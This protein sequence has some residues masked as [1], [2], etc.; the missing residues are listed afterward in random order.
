MSNRYADVWADAADAASVHRERNAVS[1]RYR[2]MLALTDDLLGRLE[3]LN[4]SGGGEL[5]RQARATIER[6]VVRLDPDLQVGLL[7]CG[8]V[9]EAVDAVLAV[10][11]EV[12]RRLHG[13]APAERERRSA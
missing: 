1:R 13:R 8:T 12:L 4:A 2:R 10:Q 5:S 3:S 11:D 9:Q 7:G 6:V